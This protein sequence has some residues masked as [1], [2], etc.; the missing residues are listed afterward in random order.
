MNSKSTT[1]ET[2]GL[3]VMQ[4]QA[5]SLIAKAIDKNV[6]VETMEKLLAM[7]R[8]LQEEWAKRRFVEAMSAFQAECPVIE[9]GKR[10]DF[11]SK[12]TG[13]RTA[14]SYAP[15]DAIVRQVKEKIA[16]YG[17]SYTIETENTETKI[18]SVVKVR[19]VDG[20]A[21]TTRFEVPIDK[22]AFMNSQQQYGSASTFSK[23]YA[24]CNAFGILTGDE[25][26][27]TVSIAS[28]QTERAAKARLDGNGG[29]EKLSQRAGRGGA[30]PAQVAFI[31]KLLKRKGHTKDEVC[32]KFGVG[33]LDALNVLQ[34]SHVIDRLRNLSDVDERDREAEAL[35][36][37]AYRALS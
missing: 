15:L 7:R 10:V 35:A 11:T 24:F 18:V 32:A 3:T 21:E 16:I 30:T 6:S 23:R 4:G 34:A 29:V 8:E 14:Y 27:D 5:E 28:D 26:N 31:E 20:H 25:D 13:S 37:D 19:H 33:E 12:R 22:D 17:F 1:E 9:K 2:Q 36:E